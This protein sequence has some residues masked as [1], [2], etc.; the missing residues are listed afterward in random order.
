[1]S[2]LLHISSPNSEKGSSVP[3]S[4]VNHSVFALS[5]MLVPNL[6]ELPS[7]LPLKGIFLLSHKTCPIFSLSLKKIAL[8]IIMMTT[9]KVS[10]YSNLWARC[11]HQEI[12]KYKMILS[13]HLP[14]I[15][16]ASK[17]FKR[18]LHLL[19]CH[20]LSFQVCKQSSDPLCYT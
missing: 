8:L 10:I 1:M 18:Y 17:V 13:F 5:A 16:S 6:L 11:L 12:Q 3:F 20:S 9:V 19:Q 7:S 15:N 2:L 4:R 14:P